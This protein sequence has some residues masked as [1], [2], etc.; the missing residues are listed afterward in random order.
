MLKFQRQTLATTLLALACALALSGCGQ[1]TIVM[2]DRDPAM[3]AR[4]A[5]LDVWVKDANGKMIRAKRDV[6]P[7]EFVVGDANGTKAPP[8]DKVAPPVPAAPKQ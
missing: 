1:K 4:T 7:G 6:L 5:T 3:I 8:A 2:R